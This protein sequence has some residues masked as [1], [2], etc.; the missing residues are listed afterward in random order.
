MS[1]QSLPAFCWWSSGLFSIYAGPLLPCSRFLYPLSFFAAFP[2]TWA[3]LFL[4]CALL[5]RPDF[6]SAEYRP[7]VSPESVFFGFPGWWQTTL[8]SRCCKFFPNRP[9]S[10]GRTA[11]PSTESGGPYEA[12]GSFRFACF[13]AFGRCLFRNAHWPSGFRESCRLQ[14]QTFS[15]PPFVSEKQGAQ[16]LH[17]NVF[18][19]QSSARFIMRDTPLAIGTKRVCMANFAVWRKIQWKNFGKKEIFRRKEWF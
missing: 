10:L 8:L 2:M 11:R 16:R 12:E 18:F 13:P 9:G 1:R 6:F 4:Y 3:A 15:V 19:L 17:P 14:G 5:R 7:S